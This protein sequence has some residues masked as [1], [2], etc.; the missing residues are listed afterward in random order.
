MEV[1][2]TT[3]DDWVASRFVQWLYIVLAILLIAG[4][5]TL[6]PI[7]LR[8]DLGKRG[9]YYRATVGPFATAEQA[10]QMCLSLEAAGGQCVAQSN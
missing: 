6:Y 1:A 7:I 2:M 5:V 4:L 8:A 10:Q 3:G 9:A